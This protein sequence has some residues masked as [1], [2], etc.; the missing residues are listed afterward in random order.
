MNPYRNT[1]SSPSA[2]Q[3]LL[4]AV[5]NFRTGFTGFCFSKNAHSLGWVFCT[6][7]IRVSTNSPSLG[8]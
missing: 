1:E 4:K 6:K 3:A 5:Q 8:S 7:R 2:S